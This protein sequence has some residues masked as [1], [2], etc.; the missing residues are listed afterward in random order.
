MDKPKKTKVPDLPSSHCCHICL[1]L[2]SLLLRSVV[3]FPLSGQITPF[4]S[5]TFASIHPVPSSLSSKG[6]HFNHFL[7]IVPVF[8]YAN[9][10]KYDSIILFPHCTQADI[11]GH[12]PNLFSCNNPS[13]GSF[14]SQPSTGFP[15]L[16]N[17]SQRPPLHALLHRRS[18]FLPLLCV[19][20]L[21]SLLHQA[22]PLQDPET[23]P[24]L[25]ALF[26]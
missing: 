19:P 14:I 10:N 3:C 26:S 18:A 5:L 17:R 6:H 1:P 11:M 16:R 2:G 22:L 7:G 21:H 15:W 13:R 12:C 20:A 4:L 9:T 23:L 24:L 25:R 8:L